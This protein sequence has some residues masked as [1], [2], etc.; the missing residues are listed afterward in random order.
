MVRRISVP[1]ITG[2]LLLFVSLLV[3]FGWISQNPILVSVIPQH[4]NLVFNAALCFLL[5][6]VALVIPSY[7]VRFQVVARRWI[8]FLILCISALTLS[9]NLLHYSSGIDQLFTSADMD[10]L[11]PHPGRMGN[12]TAVLFMLVGAVFA[13]W[14]HK[15]TKQLAFLM[16][17]T[18]FATVFVGL[19][20]LTGYW[21]KLEFLYHTHMAMRMSIYTAVN[22]TVLSLGLWA[23]S[24]KH[25]P[26]IPFYHN[27]DDKRILLVSVTILFIVALIGELSGFSVFSAQNENTIKNNM[28]QELERRVN[29][30]GDDINDALKKVNSI[31]SNKSFEAI[32][33]TPPSNITDQLNLL[34]MSRGF[35]AITITN[36]DGKSIYSSG[37]ATPFLHSITR[38]HLA[39][40]YDAE[41]M[42]NNGWILRVVKKLSYHG[43]NTSSMVIEYPLR[44]TNQMYD[45]GSDL[46]KTAKFFICGAHTADQVICASRAL[47][48][49]PFVGSYFANN[50]HLSINR[51]LLGKRGEGLELDANNNEVFTAYSPIGSLGLGVVVKMDTA[52]LYE[53]VRG[54]LEIVIPI[55]FLS[56][57]VGMLLLS[58]QVSPLV[59]KILISEKIALSS[60]ARLRE[61]ESR[62]RS[63]FDMSAIGM[64]LVSLDG[65]WLRVNPSLCQILGFTETEFLDM[66]WQRVIYSEDMD[67]TIKKLQQ[68]AE[69]KV[70]RLRMERRF[71]TKQNKMLWV[72]VNASIVHDINN[73][74]L[75]FIFQVQ[76]IDVQK[77]AEDQLK[78]MAYHDPLTG[79]D[80]R[81]EIEK[82]IHAALL[83]SQVNHN[84]F[85]LMFLDLDHFKEVNDNYGHD[86]GDL[87]LKEVADRLRATMRRTDKIGRLGGDEFVVLLTDILDL[88]VISVIA[89][90]IL[91]AMSLPFLLND[92][93]IDITTSVGVSIYPDDGLSMETLMKHA[94]IALYCAKEFGKNN[95]QF[96]GGVSIRP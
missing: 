8:G 6:G 94:D 75:Y 21:L 95:H 57:S 54:Q 73:K 46:G 17:F 58:W 50:K 65:R 20:S 91:K 13:L 90:K 80:N 45:S 92:H 19:S 34:F 67:K 86:V 43:T 29:A 41:L 2:S 69:G 71:L 44:N 25:V 74:P 81:S 1:F 33:Q 76:N 93:Q 87:L 22:F 60:N 72:L 24:S 78:M 14:S 70:H 11:N 30:F 96:F 89:K 10:M 83:A 5:S 49:G 16:R 26:L 37:H 82:N 36:A 7:S 38:V 85:A 35:S 39:V 79:L 77:R 56:I 18:I 15:P 51:A 64:A 52:E 47:D 53:P 32:L 40:P 23:I 62:F 84:G 12:S 66:D 31:T 48:T 55:F 3:L 28:Q 42:W 4:I 68:L 27:R 59:K 61:S 63:A 9:Q 88:K